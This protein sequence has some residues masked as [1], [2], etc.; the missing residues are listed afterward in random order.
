[1]NEPHN[2]GGLTRGKGERNFSSLKKARGG[3]GPIKDR[4]REGGLHII[5]TISIFS[6]WRLQTLFGINGVTSVTWVSA[7]RA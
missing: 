1:M 7:P 3:P 5:E 4:S 6:P 2:L